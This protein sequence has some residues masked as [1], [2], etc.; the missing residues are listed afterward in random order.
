MSRFVHLLPVAFLMTFVGL[1]AARADI[2]SMLL[3]VCEPNAPYFSIETLTVETDADLGLSALNAPVSGDVMRPLRSMID[4]PIEC[5]VGKRKVQATLTEF[6]EPNA[7]RA[8][9]AANIVITIDGVVAAELHATHRKQEWNG[10][11]RA[12]VEVSAFFVQTCESTTNEWLEKSPPDRKDHER[13]VL[14]CNSKFLP[15]P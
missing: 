4:R 9:E 1:G 13:R 6:Y 8:L 14:L 2:K 3:V 5:V 12:R 10:Q 15:R 11:D 7:R